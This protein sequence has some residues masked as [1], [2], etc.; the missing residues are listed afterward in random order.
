[1]SFKCETCGNNYQWKQDLKRHQTTK[2]SASPFVKE[3]I[4]CDA[5]FKDRVE[6]FKHIRENHGFHD[7]VRDVHVPPMS[8]A[9]FKS[10]EKKLE[11]ST[12]K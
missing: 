10:Q 12:Q 1:M 8:D 4:H 3:C 5:I 9:D 6:Y 7:G 2:H 11:K